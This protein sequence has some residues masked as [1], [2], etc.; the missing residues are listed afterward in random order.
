MY[1]I[2]TWVPRVSDSMSSGNVTES[3]SDLAWV[4]EVNHGC[5]YCVNRGQKSFLACVAHFKM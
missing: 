1:S 4:I 2:D 5:I 3:E